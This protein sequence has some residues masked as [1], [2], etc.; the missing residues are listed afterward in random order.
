VPY[1]RRTATNLA[2]YPRAQTIHGKLSEAASS[3]RVDAAA[4][5]EDIR[6]K[7]LRGQIVAEESHAPFTLGVDV[8]LARH[9]EFLY[10]ALLPCVA[11][12]SR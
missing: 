1:G 10:D 5:A 11:D 12:G 4:D 6:A 9:A 2:S 7:A 3:G 8:E